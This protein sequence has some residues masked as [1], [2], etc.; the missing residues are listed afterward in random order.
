[1]V[2]TPTQFPTGGLAGRETLVLLVEFE[3]VKNA[4]A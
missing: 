2:H 3:G 4:R 1:M